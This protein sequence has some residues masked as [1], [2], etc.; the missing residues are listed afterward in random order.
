MHILLDMDGTICDWNTW[1]D[2]HIDDLYPKIADRLPRA[3]SARDFD[4]FK[5]L[6][7][8]EAAA[9]THIFNHRGFYADI[10]PMEGALEAIDRMYEAGHTVNFVTSPWYTNTTCMQDKADWIARHLGEESLTD[11]IITKDKTTIRG[12]FLIDDKPHVT[13]KHRPD[14]THILFDQPYNKLL[15]KPRISNWDEWE[16]VIKD[17]QFDMI[18]G[19]YDEEDYQ[20]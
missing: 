11:L 13:G 1:F 2:K 4:L 8:E 15:G 12:D 18:L 19:A 3:S 9:V 14:W 17:W 16:Q 7:V 10:P 6:G 5:G 20:R